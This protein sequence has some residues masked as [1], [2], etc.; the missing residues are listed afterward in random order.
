MLALMQIFHLIYI[1]VWKAAQLKGQEH[2]LQPWALIPV[3]H[4]SVSSLVI[5][6]LWFLIC[7]SEKF[8]KILLKIK[9]KT[10]KTPEY[11]ISASR[12]IYQFMFVYYVMSFTFK[13][14]E[15]RFIS[16]MYLVNILFFDINLY[17]GILLK[18]INYSIFHGTVV[19]KGVSFDGY[20]N[21][22]YIIKFCL[23]MIGEFFG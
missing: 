17:R 6:L 22:V 20:W 13:G 8:G 12:Y 4:F 9:N 3:P 16:F 15:T 23:L 19:E 2:R 14:S 21:R 10:F 18:Q 7:L 11:L 5:W 1:P